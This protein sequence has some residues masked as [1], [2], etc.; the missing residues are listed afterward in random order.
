MDLFDLWAQSKTSDE[1]FRVEYGLTS[2]QI[3]DGF[4]TNRKIYPP[5]R[6][7]LYRKPHHAGDIE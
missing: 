3:Q 5:D 2:D 4:S 6:Y 7:L 1:R